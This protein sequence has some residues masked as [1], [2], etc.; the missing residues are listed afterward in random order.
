MCPLSYYQIM[1]NCKDK[2]AHRYQM[3]QYALSHGLKPTA[4]LFG[5]S[6]PVVRKWLTRFKELGYA[7]LSDLSRKPHH[8]PR[9]TAQDIKDHIVALKKNIT[10][11]ERNRLKPLKI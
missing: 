11:W 6:P 8:S 7:G 10:A 3:V 9:A 4:R 5:T 2:R 1:R